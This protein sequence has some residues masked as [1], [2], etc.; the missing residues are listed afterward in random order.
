MCS[1]DLDC[2]GDGY[3]GASEAHVFGD[4]NVRDQDPCGTAAWPSDFVSGGI[5]DSTD[6][7]TIT[8]LTSFL[9]P[10]RHFNTSPP[11]AEYADRWDLVPGAGLFSKVINISDLTALLAGSSGNPPM[12]GGAK[13]FGGPSCPWAP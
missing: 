3:K 10:V 4:T 11:S 5:P 6:R 9:A 12:L 7:V 2:D 13:A 8:D 1:S